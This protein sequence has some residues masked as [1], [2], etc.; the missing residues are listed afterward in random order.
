MRGT[1]G[2]TP[3]TGH[4]CGCLFESFTDWKLFTRV[5]VGSIIHKYCCFAILST[6]DQ[7]FTGSHLM[8]LK[9]S[10]RSLDGFNNSSAERKVNTRYCRNNV[11]RLVFDYFQRLSHTYL[12]R[13]RI[14]RRHYWNVNLYF[15][16]TI[17]HS[18]DCC[19]KRSN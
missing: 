10:V 3:L 8:H 5:G 9:R 11:L 15:S 16:F 1:S 19:W 18:I 17:E 12:T 6:A 4:P 2:F 7:R 14:P 13:R